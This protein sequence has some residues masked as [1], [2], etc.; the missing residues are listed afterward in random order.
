MRRLLLSLVVLALVGC[1]KI[2]EVKPS[3]DYWV[4]DSAWTLRETAYKISSRA[5]DAP[6]SV[7]QM[8]E[9][10]N[11][12]HTEDQLFIMSEETPIEEGPLCDAY[13][14]NPAT[15]EPIKQ[16]LDIERAD[17][18]ARRDIYKLEAY[19]SGG[20]L[21][22][23]RIPPPPV[24]VVPL[25]DYERYA[26]YL[27]AP[28]GTIDAETHCEQWQAEGYATIEACYNS[29]LYMYKASAQDRGPG[30]SYHAGS[31]YPPKQE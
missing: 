26:L 18:A 20:V 8:V 7:V 4:Y 21:Y 28:D 22:I 6:L 10:Y 17:V 24:V 11:A 27:I 9:N 14:V 29:Y 25:P 15:N 1:T 5:T 16:Y 3:P 13:I 12:T 30:W 31:L 2:I 23:D 19:A